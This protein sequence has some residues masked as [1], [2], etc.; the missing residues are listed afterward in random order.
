MEA[1]TLDYETDRELETSGRETRTRPPEQ[2]ARRP[3]QWGKRL[4]IF[5]V[6]LVVAAVGF[7]FWMGTWNRESTDDAQVDGHIAPVAPKISGNVVD[8]LV[9]DNQQVKQGQVLVRIDPRD[10]QAKVDQAK[11]AL[12]VAQSQAAGATANVPLTR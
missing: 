4:L 9:N 2:R 6:L 1:K 8:V 3:R 10:Y 5:A 7:Y 12:S 11:A